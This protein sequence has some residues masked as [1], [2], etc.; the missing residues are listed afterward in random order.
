MYS[1]VGIIIGAVVTALFGLYVFVPDGGLRAFNYWLSIWQPIEWDAPT[2]TSPPFLEQEGAYRSPLCLR[3]EEIEKEKKVTDEDIRPFTTEEEF[4]VRMRELADYLGL[5]IETLLAPRVE[6]GP[7]SRMLGFQEAVLASFV[8]LWHHLVFVPHIL[9]GLLVIALAQKSYALRKE[10]SLYEVEKRK[11]AERLEEQRGKEAL[12]KTSPSELPGTKGL[13][14][15]RRRPG[16]RNSKRD[17]KAEKR[18][19]QAERKLAMLGW[20]EEALE[21]THEKR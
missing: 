18:R 12:D 16:K 7:H 3:I 11:I 8:V 1:H 20:A 21:E 4:M 17:H 5:D 10:R 14:S 2:V 13:P 6:P 9:P 19:K 15:K